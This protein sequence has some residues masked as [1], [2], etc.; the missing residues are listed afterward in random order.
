MDKRI[1]RKITLSLIA[2]AM[3]F[4]FSDREDSSVV[5]AVESSVTSTSIGRATKVI[6]SHNIIIENNNNKE[7]E[8]KLM[9]DKDVINILLIGQDRR[10]DEERQRSDSMII[11]TL[12]KNSDK[13]LLTS[14]MRDLYVDIPG[15]GGNRLNAAYALGGMELLDETIEQNFGINID[16]NVEVDFE[17][18]ISAISVIGN[19]DI[20]LRQEE[21]DKINENIPDP[22][23]LVEG[24]NSM[25]PEQLLDYARLRK[26][27]NKDYERTERQRKVLTKAFEKVKD[28]SLSEMIK[29][30]NKVY[31][32]LEI[33]MEYKDILTCISYV[34]F[35]DID[36][37]DSQRVPIDNAFKD[38]K[39]R[40]MQVL[41]PDLELNRQYLHET[42]YGVNELENK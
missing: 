5:K 37:I 28:S 25:N 34:V 11:C 3:V 36:E 7:K 27:G 16:G 10:E 18:F 33:D 40:G 32:Y 12:S 8:I 2:I 24:I 22:G 26:V 1:I 31:P 17:G 29:L 35:K 20:E 39:I 38:E 23:N 15:H 30:F 41:V 42:I 13:I 6:D 9:D 19:L 14:L 21:A 4:M